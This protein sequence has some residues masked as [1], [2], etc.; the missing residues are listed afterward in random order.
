LAR[1]ETSAPKL[2]RTYVQADISE[3]KSNT[4]QAT[5]GHG[6]S[7]QYARTR[8]N[9]YSFAVR[10]GEKWNNPPDDIKSAPNGEVFRNRMAKL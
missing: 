3:W 2:R 9:K 4:R 8:E 7:V 6:L 10:T 1:R 5:S